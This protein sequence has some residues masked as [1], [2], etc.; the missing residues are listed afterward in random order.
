[1]RIAM[2]ATSDLSYPSPRGRWLPL[3]RELVRAGCRIGLLMT[4]ATF[5][6][7][8]AAQR[9]ALIGGVETRYVAQMHVYGV[10]GARR[11]YGPLELVRVALSGALALAR[12]CLEFRPDAIHVCKPQPI[13]GLAGLIAARILRRPLF[14]DCDDYEAANNRFGGVWQRRIVEF[15]EDR[16]PL[17]ARAVTVNTHF[18]EQRCRT[19]GM[20]PAR[21]CYV[22]NGI[23][24]EQLEPPDRRRVAGLH[25]ALGLADRPVVLYVGAL[26]E[27][28]HNVGLLLEAFA[29]LAHTNGDA[30]LL[31]VGDGDD[32]GQL[33]RRAHDLGIAERVIFTGAVPAAQVPLFLALASCSVDPV[34]DTDV[35]RGRS[36]LKIV[37]SM[38]AGV[39]VVTGDVGDRAEML[40]NGQA[41][42][43]VRPGDA[44]ALAGGIQRVLEDPALRERLTAGAR[45]Q[46]PAYHWEQLSRTWLSVYTGHR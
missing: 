31:L 17:R 29:R 38:A 9:A 18:L 22:P 28:S 21:I 23:S 45:R 7:L 27:V 41:G 6:R 30:G 12:A 3:G 37:E 43:L 5:D 15:W 35:A 39:P 16:L 36:P 20:D 13:N 8:P 32:R 42:I 33:Q 46:A 2:L 11:H 40:G 4:H 10:P 24:A 19:I 26:S 44:A 34:G 14:V 25:A 1:M